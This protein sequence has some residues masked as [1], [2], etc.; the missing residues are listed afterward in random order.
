MALSEGIARLSPARPYLRRVTAG[1]PLAAEPSDAA[2]Q[3]EAVA[4]AGG[5]VWIVVAE[6]TLRYMGLG[7]SQLRTAARNLVRLAAAAAASRGNCQRDWR[8][9]AQPHAG[10]AA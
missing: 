8:R 5:V 7:C 1:D 3:L 6:P 4:A 9:P 2:V 10:V